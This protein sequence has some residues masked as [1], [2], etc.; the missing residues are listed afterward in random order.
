[1][2]SQ[3]TFVR[4]HLQIPVRYARKENVIMQRTCENIR[5][6]GYHRNADFAID[7]ASVSLS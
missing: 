2:Y 1:M 3:S 7:I 5:L 6:K 4:H